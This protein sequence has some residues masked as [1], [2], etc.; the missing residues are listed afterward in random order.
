MTINQLTQACKGKGARSSM[1]VDKRSSTFS[2]SVI[3][4]THLCS[5]RYFY[6]MISSSHMSALPKFDF[7]CDL[8]GI[9]ILLP[10][11]HS[12]TSHQQQPG[13]GLLAYQYQLIFRKSNLIRLFRIVSLRSVGRSLGRVKMFRSLASGGSQFFKLL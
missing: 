12:C 3:N 4:C 11:L 2:Q 7:S 1:C 5:C 6:H 8:W 13:N 10:A 9:P